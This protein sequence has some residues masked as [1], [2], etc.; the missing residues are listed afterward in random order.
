M[1]ISKNYYTISKKLSEQIF[2]ELKQE[3]AN[4]SK[5][6]K[7]KEDLKIQQ[8]INTMIS[9][10]EA[11][12]KEH[13][14]KLSAEKLSHFKFLAGMATELAQNL[15]LNIYAK[16][17]K[18]LTGYIRFTGCIFILTDFLSESYKTIF[19]QLIKDS[20]EMYI[21]TTEQD[22]ESLYTI[23]FWYPLYDD[24]SIDSKNAT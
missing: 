11:E 21:S 7:E 9:S 8:E 13:A 23:E 12:K 22:G 4:M 3:H 2:T 16:T 18:N 19:L 24:L 1:K 17:R 14:R 6:E 10:A 5:S 15:Q 20:R